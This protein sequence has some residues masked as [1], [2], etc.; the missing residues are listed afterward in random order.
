MS[1]VFPRAMGRNLP[2]VA[3]GEG[4]LVWDTS[5][6]RYIDASGG[7]IVVGIGHGDSTVIEALARQAGQISYVHGSQFTSEPLEDY[8]R[9][10][11]PL[12]P[13]DDARIYP[14]SGGSEAVETALKIARAYFVAT[15]Q[16]SR[17]KVIGRQG[18]YHGNTL[19]ALDASGRDV[20]R[21]PYR[22]WL[23]RTVRV[24][25][26]YEYRCELPAHPQACGARHAEVLDD[27]IRREGPETVACFIAEPV[28]GAALG[29]VPPP[30]DY[31]S[32]IETV[33]RDHGALLVA[34]EVMTGFGRT[35]SMFGCEHWDVRPDIL[36]AGK[37]ASSG[38][39]PFGF[40][41]CSGAIFE[42]LAGPGFTHG[43]TYSHS[44]VGAAVAGAVLRRLQDDDLVAASRNKGEML[45]KLLVDALGDHEVVGD[46]RGLGM[47]IGVEL[48]A[49]RD[50]KTP[51]ERD[52]RLT[53]RILAAAKE[54]GVLMYPSTGGADG[55]NG[56]VIMLGPPFVITED[57]I[58]EVVEILTGA[59]ND[60]VAQA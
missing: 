58:H 37:G 48:V 13:I 27:T 15:G 32:A 53:E 11:A 40:A 51:F 38:Y 50:A 22:P 35:G 23:G 55:R 26:A 21:S 44:V 19:G 4:A 14:V 49:D 41:A 24:P 10:V 25:A 5:G 9:Q 52:R 3:R 30:A 31:W 29:A 45:L 6:V 8:A 17:H 56:D 59:L 2:V 33:C 12:L 18:S 57:Q 16:D 60:V 20:L 46:I 1:Y 54:R 28:V 36:A 7:A 47:M 42:A 43:F 34:D 39:W